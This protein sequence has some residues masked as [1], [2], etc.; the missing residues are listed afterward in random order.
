M[1]TKLILCA[2]QSCE[3]QMIFMKDEDEQLIYTRVHLTKKT[4]WQRLKYSIK[5]IFGHQSMFGAFDEMML[6]HTHS[7]SLIE[8]GEFLKDNKKL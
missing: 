3:H 5:Y 4:F 6:D 7:E 1:D 8:M 2:C